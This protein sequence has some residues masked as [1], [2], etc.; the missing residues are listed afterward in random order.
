MLLITTLSM[1]R[2]PR[3]M[4]LTATET[5][6]DGIVGT[7]TIATALDLV[8]HFPTM[9]EVLVMA[10][11]MVTTPTTVVTTHIIPL[12]T[13]IMVMV[14]DMAT[15]HTMAAIMVMAADTGTMLIALHHGEPAVM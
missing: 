6:E 10:V 2:V 11:D 14:E 13:T 1:V 3:F 9:V 5:I 4:L 7:A 15:T 12:I 8:L